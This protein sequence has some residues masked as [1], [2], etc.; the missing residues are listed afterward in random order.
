MVTVLLAAL[1]SIA[2]RLLASMAA[3]SF[4]EWAL[5]WVLDLVV[6]STKTPHDD[7]WLQ[8]TKEAYFAADSASKN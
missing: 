7:L 8:K 5:F 2:L 4:L 6:A 1:R 3:K